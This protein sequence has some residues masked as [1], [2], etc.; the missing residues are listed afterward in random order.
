MPKGLIEQSTLTAIA[1]A[2]RAK[3]ETTDTML[4]SEMAGLIEAISTGVELPS[5]ITEMEFAEV[6]A[7]GASNMKVSTS[8]SKVP[9][10]YLFYSKTASKI[11]SNKEI[12]MAFKPSTIARLCVVEYETSG[13]LTAKTSEA[14]NAYANLIRTSLS[15]GVVTFEVTTTY[16]MFD[17]TAPYMVIMW[18]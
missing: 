12:L 2:I 1:D 8:L 11:T 14:T 3:T 16:L 6:T 17:T 18:R 4:P 5:W 9:T 7:S 10:G 15:D 13:G